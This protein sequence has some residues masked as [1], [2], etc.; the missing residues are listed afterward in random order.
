MKISRIAG[1]IALATLAG[2][3][4]TKGSQTYSAASQT[5]ASS[6]IIGKAAEDF[7]DADI[8]VPAYFSTQG[9]EFC[10][11][12]QGSAETD[13]RC[14]LAKKT[15]RIYFSDVKNEVA[16]DATG[17]VFKDISASI[18]AYDIKALENALENQFAGVNRFR[19][20]TRDNRIV[21]KAMEEIINEE[22]LD[23]VADKRDN[24]Q[25][26]TTDY[27]INVD[28][29]KTADMMYGAK[30]SL[31]SSSIDYSTSVL[32][33]YTK[34]KL[35][36][37]NIGRIKVNN[38]DVREKEKFTSVI[39]NGDYYRGFNY[40]SASD[41]TAVYNSMATRGFDIMLSR[42]LTEMPATGQV[43][44][45]R[46]DR[47]VLDRGQNAGVLPNETM[48]IFEYS[49]GFVD[50]VGVARFSPSAI[51]AQGKIVRWKDSKI[52][53]NIRDQAEE[54]RYIP[55]RDARLF[56][57]SVGVPAEFLMER[58]TWSAN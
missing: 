21:N 17:T 15:V 31:Y 35:S 12:E 40:A 14:P 33:P 22:G 19:I 55:T 42:L 39:V 53:D 44:G 36:Y 29:L 5:N 25:K 16:G 51:G 23:V 6:V 52:A 13:S 3:Q 32:D 45:I 34:E 7:T 24:S 18:N 54:G 28:V 41:V 11:F 47:V 50:P 20:L 46:G 9:L 38:F 30:H 56:A 1:L 26:L 27:L 48:V 43:S 8:E 4:Q 49:A 57:V 10:H 37:P 58:S 2:C